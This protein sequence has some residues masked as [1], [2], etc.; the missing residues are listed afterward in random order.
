MNLEKVHFVGLCSVLSYLLNN[1]ARN[2]LG[3]K[4]IVKKLVELT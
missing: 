2:K 3:E 1:I 4:E